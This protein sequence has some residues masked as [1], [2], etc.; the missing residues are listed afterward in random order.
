MR[1]DGSGKSH[2]EA[3]DNLTAG[4]VAFQDSGYKPISISVG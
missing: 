2:D 3:I 1:F 4:W